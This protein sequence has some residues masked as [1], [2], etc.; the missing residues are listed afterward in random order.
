MAEQAEAPSG[1]LTLAPE[2]GAAAW[3]AA[4]LAA[5]GFAVGMTAGLSKAEGTATTLLSALFSFVGGVLLTFGGFVVRGRD[6]GEVSVSGRRLGSALLGFSVGIVL[7]TNAGIYMRVAGGGGAAGASRGR[8]RPD[9]H[10]G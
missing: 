6:G 5:F 1:T 7:G 3:L 2:R 9:R 4:G 8:T 10:R